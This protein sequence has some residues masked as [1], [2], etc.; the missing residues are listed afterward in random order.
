MDIEIKL[1]EDKIN[2]AFDNLILEYKKEND[3][4][5]KTV[6]DLQKQNKKLKNIVINLIKG[7]NPSKKDC[8]FHNVND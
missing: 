8:H 5:L 6:A 2:Q 4:L 7:N 3:K 1:I